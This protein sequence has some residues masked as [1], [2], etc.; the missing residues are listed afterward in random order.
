M[1]ARLGLAADRALFYVTAGPAFGHFNSAVNSF[2]PPRFPDVFV[3]AD[4]SWHLGAAVG[5][6]ME[7]MVAP[8]WS[9]RG[10]YLYLNFV[11]RAATCVPLNAAA[12]QQNCASFHHIDFANS[13]QIA[14]VGL[15]YKLDWLGPVVAKY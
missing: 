8:G 3:L 12:V 13:A 9:I 7:Y 5:A 11:E 2:G 4:N 6:G 15:N 10:E 1:R 14:R